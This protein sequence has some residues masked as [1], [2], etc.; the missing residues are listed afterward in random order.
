MST[1]IKMLYFLLMKYFTVSTCE[2]L[3]SLQLLALSVSFGYSALGY[4]D[5]SYWLVLSNPEIN[6]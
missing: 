1:D 4:Y 5:L 2:I 6:N 3:T